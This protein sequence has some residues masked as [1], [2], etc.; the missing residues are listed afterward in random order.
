MSARKTGKNNFTN[1]YYAFMAK[2][3]SCKK[4]VEQDEYLEEET[5]DDESDIQGEVDYE[6]ELIMALDYLDKETEKKGV[7]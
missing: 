3:S 5:S 6:Q 2:N 7:C 1:D 4:N